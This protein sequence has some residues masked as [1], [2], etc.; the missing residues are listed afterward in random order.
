M[1]ELFWAGFGGML[2]ALAVVFIIIFGAGFLVR[3]KIVT[4]EHIDSLSKLTVTVL[5]PC[6]IFSNT[7]SEFKP[8]ELPQ[9]WLLPLVGIV[10]SLIGVGISVLFFA[11][12]LKKH[13]NMIAVASM[14]NAGYLVLPIGQVVYPEQFKEFALITFLFILGYNPLLWTLGKHLA[15]ATHEKVKINFKMLISPPAVTNISTLIIVLLGL[16][17]YFPKVFIDSAEMLGKATVPS[18]NFVLGA[19]LGTISLR[20][21]PDFLDILRVTAIRYLIIPIATIAVLYWLRLWETQPLLADFFV[22]QSAAAPATAIMLQVRAYGG[23]Q[24]KVGSMMLWAYLICLVAL[25]FWIAIW[26]TIIKM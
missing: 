14:Q 16:A 3:K 6:M 10:M 24:Q 2:N 18:A 4:D 25:P 15:T 26:H 12:N 17:P 1:T 13:R 11:D 21:F 23:E 20:K 5:M 22:I 9:W 7:L 8:Q 19:T